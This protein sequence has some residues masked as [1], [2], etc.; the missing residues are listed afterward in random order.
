MAEAVEFLAAP[1]L[2]GWGLRLGYSLI[3]AAAIAT[4]PLRLRSVLG[5]SARVGAE[6]AG[7][8]LVASLRW[9]LGASPSWQLAL[10]R[11][12]AEVPPGLFRQP[13]PA[14]VA[15]SRPA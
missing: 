10:A 3:H 7:K 9:A 14:P 5:V 15:I 4:L 1:P 2:P 13:L 6:A 11:V 12:G 8:R